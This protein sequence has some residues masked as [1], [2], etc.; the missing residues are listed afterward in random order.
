MVTRLIVVLFHNVCK[1]HI[2]GTPETN[3]TLL[4]NCISINQS[5]KYLLSI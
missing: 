4:V 1:C 2:T 5:I 3:I